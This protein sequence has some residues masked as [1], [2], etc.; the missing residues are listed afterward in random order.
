M[1]IEIR[2]E[3]TLNE[4]RKEQWNNDEISTRGLFSRLIGSLLLFLKAYR[5]LLNV[6]LRK[7]PNVINKHSVEESKFYKIEQKETISTFSSTNKIEV[8]LFSYFFL[9][10]NDTEQTQVALRAL[11]LRL[12][13]R[14]DN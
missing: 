1:D 11:G 12:L 6:K 10:L 13:C 4:V 3:D 8:F 9:S 14:D 5:I 7:I 2:S